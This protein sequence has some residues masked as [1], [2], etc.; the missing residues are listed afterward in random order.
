[1]E[2]RRDQLVV[3]AAGY[4]EPMQAFLRSNP[5][6]PSRFT[7]TIDFPSYGTDELV[8]IF[9]GFA[10]AEGLQVDPEG[11]PALLQYFDEARTRPDFANARTVRT[12]LERA[13]EAQALRLSPILALSAADLTALTW[14]D[15]ETA[16]W[17]AA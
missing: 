9:R 4:A 15:I 11:E 16:T 7:K 5:G 17:K 14:D 6:L 3:I 13:R 8:R 12:L 2:D 10:E 1:M